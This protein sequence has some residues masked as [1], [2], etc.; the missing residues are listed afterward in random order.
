MSVQYLYSKEY[1]LLIHVI[2]N[3]VYDARVAYGQQH[4]II[5]SQILFQSMKEGMSDTIEV[6]AHGQHIGYDGIHAI[7]FQPFGVFFPAFIIDNVVE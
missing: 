1:L 3:G 5:F 4:M 7:Y 6:H 2:E